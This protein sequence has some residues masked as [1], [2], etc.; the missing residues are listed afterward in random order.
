MPNYALCLVPD[1]I[2]V[3]KCCSRL[4]DAPLGL[5]TLCFKYFFFL[6]PPF[7]LTSSLETQTPLGTG[8]G[9]VSV[10]S[11]TPW[12]ENKWACGHQAQDNS[13]EMFLIILGG[14]R[15]KSQVVNYMIVK[16]A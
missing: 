8:D 7:R 3:A 2:L 14:K 6:H 13:G 15:R 12:G 9:T 5:F 16:L 4:T 11:R 1:S 10:E